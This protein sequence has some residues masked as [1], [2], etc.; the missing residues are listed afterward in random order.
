M[1]S[2]NLAASTIEIQPN[3]QV[4]KQRI[5]GNYDCVNRICGWEHSWGNNGSRA[6]R[7]A[8]P[9]MWH[10]RLKRPG[11]CLAQG[12]TLPFDWR[13]VGVGHSILSFAHCRQ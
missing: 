3:L 13:A 6:R 1:E 5:T 8:R 10:L 9:W 7:C 2:C 12:T 4:A 11:G